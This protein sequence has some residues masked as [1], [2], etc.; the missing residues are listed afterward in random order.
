MPLIVDEHCAA[1]YT[2]T[3]TTTLRNNPGRNVTY[4]LIALEL[5]RYPLFHKT[6]SCCPGIINT[7]VAILLSNA[8]IVKHCPA[9]YTATLLRNSGRNVTYVQIA[10]D[11][12]YPLSQNLQLFIDTI[13]FGS[14]TTI[15]Q[16]W[17][18]RKRCGPVLALWR[19][20]FLP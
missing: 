13:V 8:L 2:T 9:G 16:S 4:V 10:L 1:G 12:H 20:S 6:L 19:F 18:H 17:K 11:H 7:N 15:S 3:T 5:H 14:S